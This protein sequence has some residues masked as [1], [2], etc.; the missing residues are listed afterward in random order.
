MLIKII[1]LN[2][3]SL[4]FENFNEINPSKINIFL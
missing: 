4:L 1:K 2:Q 3:F